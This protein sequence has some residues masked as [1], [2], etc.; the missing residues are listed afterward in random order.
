MSYGTERQDQP[1]ADAHLEKTP[2]EARQGVKTFRI[3]WVLVLSLL[4]AVIAVGAS[5]VWYVSA[6]ATHTAQ[7]APAAVTSEERSGG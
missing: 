7:T 6:Q 1:A 3:R 5:Y 4:L 2:V